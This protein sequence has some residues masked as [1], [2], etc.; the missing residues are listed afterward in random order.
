MTEQ[1]RDRMVEGK[2][3]RLLELR[4]GMREHAEKAGVNRCYCAACGVAEAEVVGILSSP[5][6]GHISRERA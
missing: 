3:R 4:R 6:P 2:E 5:M 1:E